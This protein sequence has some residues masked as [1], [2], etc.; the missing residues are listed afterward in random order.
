MDQSKRYGEFRLVARK[1]AKGAIE[2]RK[3]DRDDAVCLASS[4]A[5]KKEKQILE[6]I[7]YRK[8]RS[9]SAPAGFGNGA[10]HG[11]IEKSFLFFSLSQPLFLTLSLPFSSFEALNCFPATPAP[12]R[13]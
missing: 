10:V 7:L 4:S 12:A 9:G 6:M 5:T 8:R 13:H 11:A 1:E 2:T 3:R